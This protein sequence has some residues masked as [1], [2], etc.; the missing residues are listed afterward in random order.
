M[1]RKKNETP[2]IVKGDI[3]DHLDLDPQQ[4]LELKVKAD[5][6]LGILRM[7]RANHLTARELERLF[8][9][10][11]PRV[12]ELMRGKLN[13]LSIGRLL[14]YASRLGGEADVR[15]RVK[16]KLSRKAA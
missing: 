11:Q 7:I 5:I 16:R 3:F 8:D 13:V 2:V 12:S 6:H 10:P 1:P 14:W 4:A 15:M 9:V